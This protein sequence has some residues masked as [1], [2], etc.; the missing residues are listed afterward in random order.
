MTAK[1][2]REELDQL[3]RDVVSAFLQA[4]SLRWSR[5]VSIQEDAQLSREAYEHAD[6]RN[7]RCSKRL[8]K[9]SPAQTMTSIGRH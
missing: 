8:P 5:A 4:K 6:A 3:K 2:T 9:I 1:D 7:K